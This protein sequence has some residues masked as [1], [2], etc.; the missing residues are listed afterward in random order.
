MPLFCREDVKLFLFDHCSYPV[1]T[2]ISTGGEKS[3]K[4]GR[5]Q[6]GLYPLFAV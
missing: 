4:K 6:P 2:G 3:L 5:V 1:K